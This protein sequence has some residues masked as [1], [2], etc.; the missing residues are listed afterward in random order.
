MRTTFRAAL[1][2]SI[3]TT[4][5]LAG[6]GDTASAAPKKATVI[7]QVVDQNGQPRRGAT[8]IACPVVAG[9]QDCSQRITDQTNPDGIAHLKLDANLTYG[10]FSFVSNP[11]PAW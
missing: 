4:G 2:T 3:I 11:E 7:V 1:A 8:A 9:Q 10:V 6:V 5:L